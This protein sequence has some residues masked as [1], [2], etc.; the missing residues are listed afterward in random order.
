MP[1]GP[2]PGPAS[3]ALG[4]PGAVG[5]ESLALRFDER[6]V[7]HPGERLDALGVEVEQLGD[8]VSLPA[9]DGGGG[10]GEAGAG[11]AAQVALAPEE[12]GPATGG[13]SAEADLGG[14]AEEGGGL[15]GLADLEG[16][17]GRELEVHAGVGGLAQLLAGL[18]AG[19]RCDAHALLV[20][21]GVEGAEHLAVQVEHPHPAGR[22]A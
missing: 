5:G 9:P 3:G 2:E 4:D 8:D 16:G 15:E 7:A 12:I 17:A 13:G 11:G 18:G 20:P 21:E 19:E 10:D 6:G 14:A 1:V 22:A